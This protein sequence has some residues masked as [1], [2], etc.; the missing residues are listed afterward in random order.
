MGVP[1][2]SRLNQAF[3]NA[4]GQ[5]PRVR[6]SYEVGE[7]SVV[8]LDQVSMNAG[9]TTQ[10]YDLIRASV[11]MVSLACIVSMYQSGKMNCTSPNR[12]P[13]AR[14]AI[15]SGNEFSFEHSLTRL[16]ASSD[17][18]MAGWP[19]KC[20]DDRHRASDLLCTYRVA[21]AVSAICCTARSSAVSRRASIT[22]QV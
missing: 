15:S 18:A 10:M 21:S 2:V 9:S 8:R 19:A 16:L 6:M 13:K 17:R 11:R 20:N 1:D 22:G 14:W 4:I 12:R 7:W 5:E 3:C